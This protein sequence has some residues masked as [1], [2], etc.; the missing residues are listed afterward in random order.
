MGENTI[1]WYLLPVFDFFEICDQWRA[2]SSRQ[3]IVLC[4]KNLQIIM[5]K[6]YYIESRFLKKIYNN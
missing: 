4:K 6:F 2:R 1:I 5:K 3:F